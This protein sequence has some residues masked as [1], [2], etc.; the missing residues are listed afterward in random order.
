[1]RVNLRG[2]H[3]RAAL[4]LLVPAPI[5]V[6]VLVS[7][8][9][10]IHLASASSDTDDGE[11]G[12]VEEFGMP[13]E[14][15]VDAAECASVSAYRDD[16]L[17]P[18]TWFVRE[19]VETDE[20]DSVRSSHL[21]VGAAAG[22]TQRQK[23]R[24]RRWGSSGSDSPAPTYSS[25]NRVS[26]PRKRDN[27]VAR[28]RGYFH[29]APLPKLYCVGDHCDAERQPEAVHCAVVE[30]PA[31]GGA[32]PLPA[33][34]VWECAVVRPP[35]LPPTV[36][37]HSVQV[38][39][40]S[41]IDGSPVAL[42]STVGIAAVPYAELR[43]RG[44]LSYRS[45]PPQPIESTD[46][47]DAGRD[48]EQR[49]GDP[50]V[51]L[52]NTSVPPRTVL[53]ARVPGSDADDEMCAFD[54]VLRRIPLHDFVTWR[55]DAA[56]RQPRRRRVAST[57]AGRGAEQAASAAL[58]SASLLLS[59]ADVRDLMAHDD[60]LP[61]D[62]EDHHLVP[63]EVCRVQYRVQL[64]YRPA[65]VVSLAAIL[66]VIIIFFVIFVVGT[67]NK[68]AR[69]EVNRHRIR[70]ELQRCEDE[71]MKRNSAGLAAGGGH[72]NSGTG[73]SP[74]HSGRAAGN[75]AAASAR[76]PTATGSPGIVANSRGG[77]V[78]EGLAKGLT[79]DEIMLREEMLR[80]RDAAEVPPGM[81]AS[82]FVRQRQA[83]RFRGTAPHHAIDGLNGPASGDG[84]ESSESRW[85][86]DIDVP[87]GAM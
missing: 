41:T 67:T 76:L 3:L 73:W 8:I 21:D 69:E 1:M 60:E 66:F 2:R 54:V 40:Q 33:A 55:R 72:R 53:L 59:A 12:V 77:A 81:S 86:P 43:K 16:T 28:V 38:E 10:A 17:P 79:L 24:R 15:A 32:L 45:P 5:L 75:I 63:A 35:K 6:L 47:G 52:D 49:G 71:L 51:D 20:D 80:R 83:E 9:A 82:Q 48:S 42:P 39:C 57:S 78:A 37:F 13:D 62:D 23:R 58:S 7:V 61:T 74:P 31:T 14:V 68:D 29:D 70:R 22:D 27:A 50:Q 19:D 26:S 64:I 30:R 18:S 85:G 36:T 56:R 34:L 46:N 11:I 87:F 25:D 4:G 44:L 65:L 84:G